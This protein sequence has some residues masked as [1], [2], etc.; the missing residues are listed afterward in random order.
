M[1]VDVYIFISEKGVITIESKCYFPKKMVD[2][3]FELTETNV[4]EYT[5][6]VL[7]IYTDLVD[8]VLKQQNLVPLIS[9]NVPSGLGMNNVKPCIYKPIFALHFHY[10]YISNSI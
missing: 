7:C 8:S 5:W 2:P 3:V 4:K 10:V 6:N 1:Y 9:R